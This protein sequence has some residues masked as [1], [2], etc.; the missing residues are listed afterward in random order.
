[1]SIGLFEVSQRSAAQI[2]KPSAPRPLAA[3]RLTQGTIN[4][5]EALRWVSAT[6]KAVIWDHPTTDLNV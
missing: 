2:V 1:M 6:R 3:T 5:M 4:L